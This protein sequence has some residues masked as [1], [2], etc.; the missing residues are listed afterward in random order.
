M[1]DYLDSEHM[2]L[3]PMNQRNTPY[4]Y[5]IPHHCILHPD[6]QTTK[7]RVVFDASATTAAGQSLN[8]SLYTGQKLQKDITQILIRARVHKFLFTADIKQMYRQIE[9]HSKDRDY[10]RIL[11]RF[12]QQMP[13]EEYRRNRVT[14][15][16]SCAPHQALRTLQHLAST[17]ED[18]FPIAANILMRDTF[19][20]DI[21]TWANSEEDVIICQQQLIA[22]CADD[23]FELRKWANNAPIVLNSV[24]AID[25]LMYP[26]VWFDDDL[27]EKFKMLGMRWSPKYD[28]FSYTFKKTTEPITK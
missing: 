23:K 25:C 5:Y 27:E 3:V 26:T 28:Y 21:L 8:N 14:Y 12:D 19:M 18:R 1:R 10:L 9:I 16:T 22:L 15:G 6:S 7:L 17:E 24:P 11:W 20:D 13:I 4:C 2:E